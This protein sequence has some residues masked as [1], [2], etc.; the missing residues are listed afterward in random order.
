ML[1]NRSKFRTFML[2]GWLFG[3]VASALHARQAQETDDSSHDRQQQLVQ[4][5]SDLVQSELEEKEVPAISIALVVDQQVL[6]A[7][8]FGVAQQERVDS[9]ARAASADTVYRVGSVSKLFTD[10]A[11]MQL[12]EQGKLDLDADVRT[13]LPGFQPKNGSGKPITLRQLMSHRSGLV[14]EPPVG[15]YFDATVPTVTA[16][17]DSLNGTALVYEPESRTKYSN[18]GITVVGRV[19][20]QVTGQPFETVIR[21]AILQPLEM[22]RSSFEF[23]TTVEPHLAEAVMWTYDGR[24]FNAPN[25]KLGIA[26]AGNLYSTVNDLAKFMMAVFNGGRG[27]QGEILSGDLLQQ[28]IQPQFDKNRF[29][30]GFH[31][32]EFDGTPAIG[33]GG[34]VYGFSTQW[35][36][37]P[38]KK[39]GVIAAASK[40]I[41]DGLV[42]RI[43]HYALRELLAWQSNREPPEIERTG[44]VGEIRMQQLVGSYA[45]GKKRIRLFRRGDRL[46]LDLGTYRRT[47]RSDNAGL[48]CDDEFGFGPRVAMSDGGIRVGEE[49]Y[50]RLP[51]RRPP[52]LPAKWQDFVGEYGW[53]HNTLYVYEK[54]GQLWCTIE[55]FFQYPLTQIDDRTFAFPDYGLYHGERLVF[56]SNEGAAGSVEAAK[57]EFVR[58]EVGTKNGE[59]FKIKPVNPISDIRTSAMQAKPPNEPGEFREPELV[60][61]AQLDPTIKLD[62]R[63]ASDN[64]FMGETFYSRP[65]AFLQKPAAEALVR[66]QRK[67]K[68]KGY[69]LLIHDAYRPWF[70]TKMFWDA[71]PSEMKIFVA[72]PQNGSRHN[73]GCAVDLTLFDLKTGKPIWMGAGYDEFS[74]RSFPDYPVDSS[75]ARW[76]RDLLRSSMEAEG[77]AI[78]EYEWWHF[79]YRDWRAYPILNEAFD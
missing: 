35:I 14:R 9:P 48:V 22:D 29:G 60:E 27:Q 76:H 30:I 34:A 67:L 59:T 69:G 37:L 2:V 72:N 16:T 24:T 32:S 57:I 19:L 77:F 47:L 52:Q 46:Y 42:K 62:I 21:Q 8:G 20:E 40:D 61:I 13:Y 43:S 45:N 25:F 70:V 5:I 64:N 56:A 7:G 10:L 1:G 49:E 4:R 75:S 79:D 3:L 65:A 26:P 28:M 6:F 39:V 38:E 50:E 68:K 53:D 33:H 63:Y 17:V 66:V 12:V 11:V 78:Y 54:N 71:T 74:T 55:W 41:C 51:S 36:A 18:A 23:D 73:R 31:L 58:R 15:H 44:P